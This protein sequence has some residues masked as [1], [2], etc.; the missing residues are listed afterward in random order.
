MEVKLLRMLAS[1]GI[2]F[3]P[4]GPMLLHHGIR[5][6]CFGEIPDVLERIKREQFDCWNVITNGGEL[7]QEW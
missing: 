2:H 4:I 3:E 7:A 5:Q 6:S 1:M